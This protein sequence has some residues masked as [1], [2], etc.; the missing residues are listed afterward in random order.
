M[1][2]EAYCLGR[3]GGGTQGKEAMTQFLCLLEDSQRP[4]CHSFSCGYSVG[5]THPAG[6]K[7]V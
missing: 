4:L 3:T 2:D 1:C 7:K 6:L 5:Q